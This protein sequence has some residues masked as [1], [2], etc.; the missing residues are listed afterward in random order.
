MSFSSQQQT[1]STIKL[2]FPS[3]L[4]DCNIQRNEEEVDRQTF[5]EVLKKYS[6][7]KKEY[8]FEYQKNKKLTEEVGKLRKETENKEEVEEKVSKSLVLLLTTMIIL[9][10]IVQ[11]SRRGY[12]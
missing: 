8:I 11:L 4:I 6:L 5:E 2:K 7:L 10:F 9:F 3:S 1:T 12:L